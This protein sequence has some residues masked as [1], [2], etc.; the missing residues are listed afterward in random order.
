MGRDGVLPKPEGIENTAVGGG[1]LRAMMP[2]TAATVVLQTTRTKPHL[3]FVFQVR[4][5]GRVLQRL[6]PRDVTR[7]LRRYPM[8]FQGKE[9]VELLI[10]TGKAKDTTDA[11]AIGNAFLRERSP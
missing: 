7:G 2:D 3:F 11:L 10:D 8:V 1:G 6:Q 9:A 5:H 4:K